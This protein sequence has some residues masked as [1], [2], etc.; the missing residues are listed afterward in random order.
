M[1]KRILLLILILLVFFVLPTIYAKTCIYEFYGIGCPHCAKVKPFLDELEKKYDVE[2]HR[3]EIYRNRSNLLLLNKYFDAYNVSQDERG[4]PAI[5]IGNTYLIGDSP[6]IANL[7]EKIKEFENASCPS[8]DIDGKGKKG[9]AS[10]LEGLGLGFYATIISAALVDSIN[11]CAIAVLLILLSA[12]LMSRERKKAL[13]F[14]LAFSASIYIIYFLFGLGLFSAL[15]ISTTVSSWFYKIVGFIAIAIG[16]LNIKD[17]V[18]YGAG[19]FVTEIPRRWRPKLKSMLTSVVSPL[20]AFLIGFVVCLFELPC[21]GGPYL[22]VLGLL[23]EKTSRLLAIPILLLY[24]VFFILPL[25]AL[26]LILYFGYSNVQEISAW[27]ERNIR[28][29][30]LIAGI[31]MIILGLVVILGL[32]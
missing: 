29:L 17:Y 13:Y 26:T 15:Q 30:H 14:G 5:F 22:F 9:A 12:L 11:P 32:I 16:I 27:R 21:T 3:F 23:A 1:K 31:V 25:I 6:I 7:E 18:A 8:F 4:V 19:G 20:G 28:R 2:I 10:K 24:N